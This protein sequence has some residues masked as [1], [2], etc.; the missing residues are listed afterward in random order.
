MTA[1]EEILKNIQKLNLVE[2][3]LPS[4][5]RFAIDSD[6]EDLF[7]RQLATNGATVDNMN[8][9]DYLDKN[10]P[11]GLKI[12]SSYPGI[13]GNSDASTLIEPHQ[14]E[15]MDVGIIKAE[16]GVAEN[17]ALWVADSSLT[18]R[19]MPFI[20]SH[21][22]IVLSSGC[23]VPTMHEAYSR[24]SLRQ[25]G[26]GCFIS[27]PSKTADIE[28]SLVIGAHGSLSFHVLLSDY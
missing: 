3:S 18:H 4:I 9:A 28:Q 7:R 8:V 26:F 12:L 16:F 6:Q 21:L 2:C 13:S 25:S 1:R 5:P 10:F 11:P 27:G 17:G 22:I 24:I 20:V 15:G 19:V 23:I 14:L